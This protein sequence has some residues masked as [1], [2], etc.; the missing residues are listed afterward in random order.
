MLLIRRR[1]SVLQHNSLHC[2]GSCQN[3]AYNINLILSPMVGNYTFND[4]KECNDL[5]IELA[6]TL[7]HTVWVICSSCNTRYS[8]YANLNLL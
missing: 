4:F 1:G 7:W 8:S 6:G 2:N 3:S 5:D